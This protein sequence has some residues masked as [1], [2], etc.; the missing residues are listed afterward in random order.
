[1]EIDINIKD[2]LWECLRGFR[3]WTG[4]MVIFMVG[5][6]V[7]QVVNSMGTT[8]TAPVVPSIVKQV[9]PEEA[10]EGLGY[11]EYQEVI[12]VY[13][14]QT[15]IDNK[16]IYLEDSILMNINPFAENRVVMR[17]K[18][19]AN[20]NEQQIV[21]AYESYV[22]GGDLG[23]Q[24]STEEEVGLKAEYINE[25]IS[26]EKRAADEFVVNV[27]YNIA[28]GAK[29]LAKYVDAELTSYAKQLQNHYGM[30][31][32]IDC[33]EEQESVV[34]NADLA[35]R[36]LAYATDINDNKDE[37]ARVKNE[38]SA[39]QIIVLN[40]MV[41]RQRGTVVEE[42]TE[43]PQTETT[44]PAPTQKKLEIKVSDIIISGVVGAVLGV[45]LVLAN[46]VLSAR[47]RR[48]GEVEEYYG[49][50]FLG[51]T[52]DS[53][54]EKKKVFAAIDAMIYKLENH[55]EKNIDATQLLE[56]LVSNI[57]VACKKGNVSK[58]YLTGTQIDT[59]SAEFVKQLTA[60]LQ[61]KG[62][63]AV[64]GKSILVH[65]ESMIEAA[66]VGSVVFIEKK[67]VSYYADMLKEVQLCRQNAIG[68]IGVTTVGEQ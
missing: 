51:M 55:R 9:T 20:G 2:L 8:D 46:Y 58:V 52:R 34:V 10:K 18:V 45:V 40:D 48:N 54:N 42:V 65:A 17:Y 4:M 43:T 57:Y 13:I 50:R 25:L 37:L 63:T 26:V 38:M 12:S 3:V 41:N 7:L 49:V 16:S 36:Q 32:S 61:A 15:D 66:E 33:W 67:R 27:S 35:D 5:S 1:M 14:V 39:N 62:I 21:D 60:A 53:K 30:S 24:I 68:I 59:V 44:T 11:D 47:L 56:L 19:T 31:V 23:T 22:L 28:E 29:N 64:A 6:L